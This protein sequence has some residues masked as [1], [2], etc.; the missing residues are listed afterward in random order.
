MYTAHSA[1]EF[2]DHQVRWARTVRLCRPLSYVGLL[3]TQ[4]LPWIVLAA[5]VA[6]TGAASAGYIA[7]YLILR[8]AMAWTVGIW[9]VGDEVL[10]RKIWLVPVR[11]A[12]HFVVWLASFGSNRIK[13]GSTEYVIRKGQMVPITGIE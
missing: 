1:R 13:W 11:D 7:G 12:I 8:M 6:P 10:R 5:L 3:F 2:W 9:G 4:G